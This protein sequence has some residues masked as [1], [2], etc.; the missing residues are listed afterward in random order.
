M[1]I[2][3]NAGDRVVYEGIEYEIAASPQDSTRVLIKHL[4]TGVCQPVKY[5]ELSNVGGEAAAEG[6]RPMEALSPKQLKVAEHRYSTIKCV[7]AKPGDREAV[8][9]VAD[10]QGVHIATIYRWMSLYNKFQTLAVLADKVGKGGKGKHRMSDKTA[11]VINNVIDAMLLEGST[12]EATYKEI[13][14][15]CRKKKYKIPSKNTVRNFFKS[16]SD[17]KKISRLR[18]PK[19]AQQMFDAVGFNEESIA[20]LYWCEIDH[21]QADIMCIDEETRKVIG[22]P[23]ITVVIDVYSRAVLGFY[24]SFYE[25]GSY[26]SGRAI[27]HAM[28]PKEAYLASLGLQ[29][30]RWQMWG[31]M[32]NLRC[33]NAGEFKGN[34]LK[35][36]SQA[37]GIDFEFR[38]P[39]EPRMGAYIERWLG[40]FGQRC[41]DVVGYT[42]IS[43]ELRSYF[44]PEKM[45]AL[46]LADFEKWMTLMIIQYNNE[47]HSSLGVTPQQ[48]FHYGLYNKTNPIGTPD[49]WTNEKRLR[50]DFLPHEKR[51]IQRTGVKIDNI[52]Y[53]SPVLQKYINAKDP[54]D[55][56]KKRKFIFKYDFRCI[57][58][59]YFLDPETDRYYEIPYSKLSGPKMSVVDLRKC[60]GHIQK[61]GKKVTQALIFETFELQKKLIEDAKKTTKAVL[62]AATLSKAHEKENGKKQPIA[63]VPAPESKSKINPSPFISYSTNNQTEIKPFKVYDKRSFK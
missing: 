32:N 61:N 41:K 2:S 12:F 40:T 4:K 56:K 49:R 24:C 5:H 9:K 22:R 50:L 27:V 8:Q 48:K 45:A 53:Y 30:D 42:K 17:R 19:A 20:P 7:L 58:P 55:P 26:G 52:F 62:R 13:E 38:V 10:E 34:S 23:W 21:T 57:N 63:E 31:K 36:G 25:P 15:Q 54:E 29:L 6:V 44:K 47:V 14:T 11:S 60:I 46:T 35:L 1:N 59:M 28:M 39:G 3:F 16:I 37:H 51:T 33:D 18:G 43:K